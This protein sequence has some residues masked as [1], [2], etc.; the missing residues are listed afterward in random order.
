MRK[1]RTVSRSAVTGKYVKPRYAKQHPKTTVRE[2]IKPNKLRKEREI[3]KTQKSIAINNAD[4]FS[5][6]NKGRL[7][8]ALVSD[9]CH[10]RAKT[11]GNGRTYQQWQELRK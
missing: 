1:T 3:D 4:N 6:K 11:H 2:K 5:I 7:A 9:L 8:P 10:F